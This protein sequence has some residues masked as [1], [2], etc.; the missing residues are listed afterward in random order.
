MAAVLLIPGG[1]DTPEQNENRTRWTVDVS[2]AFYSAAV[3][4]MLLTSDDVWRA[5]NDL[6]WIRATWTLACL[7][8]L[9]HVVVAFNDVHQ[10]SHS[11]AIAHTQERSGFG[12]GIFISHGFSV[13]WGVDVLWW[14]A[15]PRSY[16]RRPAWVGWSLH[17]FMLFMV[18]NGAVVYEEGPIRW[19]G[20]AMSTVFVILFFRR[21]AMNKLKR[22]PRIR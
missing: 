1:A 3:I 18:F 22:P 15:L 4:G 12:E 8:Y 7:A 20:A 9:V 5:G 14:L 19:A 21:M 17:S 10:W 16:I 6:R 11:R 2:L 13:I